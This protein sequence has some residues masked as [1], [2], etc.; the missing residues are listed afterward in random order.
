MS[1]VTKTANY[2]ATGEVTII[3]C[4]NTGGAI[5]ISLP[6][7]SGCSGRVYCIKKISGVLLECNYWTQNGA[8]TIDGSATRIL[9]VCN[10]ND[11]D[12]K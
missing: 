11:Y 6:T 8:E 1:T 9:Y 4:N 7:A 5:T 2:T 3:I 12:T 10:G